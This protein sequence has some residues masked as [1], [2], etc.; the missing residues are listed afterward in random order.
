M[1][2]N[3]NFMC[4]QELNQEHLMFPS[5]IS[6]VC[7][8]CWKYQ[9]ILWDGVLNLIAQIVWLV[10]PPISKKKYPPSPV[11][12]TGSGHHVLLMVE[13]QPIASQ[14]PL[15]MGNVL[16]IPQHLFLQSL[17]C[18]S[19][20]TISKDSKALPTLLVSVSH[21]CVWMFSLSVVSTIIE[22]YLV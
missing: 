11:M 17:H 4:I 14:T 19:F 2:D 1:N 7:T 12:K 18:K 20:S 6:W 21:P 5:M 9:T 3:Y 15:I 22:G 8:E 10:A 13:W 16:F